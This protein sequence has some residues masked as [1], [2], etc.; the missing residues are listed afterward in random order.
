MVRRLTPKCSERS[1]LERLGRFWSS[2][3]SAKRRSVL[4]SDLSALRDTLQ[5]RRPPKMPTV[6]LRCQRGVASDRWH[7]LSVAQRALL[8][9]KRPPASCREC[10]LPLATCHLLPATHP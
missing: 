10:H 4:F 1:R 9:V 8:P 2:S 6:T 7:S 3:T 5:R